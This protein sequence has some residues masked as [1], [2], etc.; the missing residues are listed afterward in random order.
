MQLWRSCS[1]WRRQAARHAAAHGAA[2]TGTRRPGLPEE[3]IRGGRG[4]PDHRQAVVHAQPRPVARAGVEREAARDVR[5]TARAGNVVSLSHRGPGPWPADRRDVAGRHLPEGIRRPDADVGRDQSA[6]SPDRGSR[7]HAD[8]G[9]GARRRVMVRRTPNRAGLEVGFLPQRVPAALRA[10][11]RSCGVRRPRRTAAG[12]CGGRAAAPGAA[13]PRH[14][15]RQRRA[16]TGAGGLAGARS[17]ST[18]HRCR[19]S[20]R[21]WTARATTSRQS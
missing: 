8:L 3:H 2:R 12:A 20:S 11:R 21:R 14:R 10:G 19:R 5:G 4:R 1:S 13:P 17:R 9:P 18:R 6:R 7:D 16:G 15:Q